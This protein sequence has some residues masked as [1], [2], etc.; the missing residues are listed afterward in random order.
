MGC[1]NFDLT[2]WQVALERE[3]G[4]PI[5]HS[6]SLSR[7]FGDDKQEWQPQRQGNGNHNDDGDDRSRLDGTY[8]RFWFT[9]RDAACSASSRRRFRFIRIRVW[10]N[11]LHDKFV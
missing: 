7:L 2:G 3:G 9:I 4:K 8:S 10:A 1:L 5:P 11:T 6:T